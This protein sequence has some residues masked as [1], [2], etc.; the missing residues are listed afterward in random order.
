VFGSFL[1]ARMRVKCSE[2]VQV[3]RVRV[4]EELLIVFNCSGLTFWSAIK[5]HCDQNPRVRNSIYKANAIENFFTATEARFLPNVKAQSRSPDSR[6]QN[7]GETDTP[8]YPTIDDAITLFAFPVIIIALSK[9]ISNLPAW[10]E[11]NGKEKKVTE[12]K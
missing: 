3:G 4:F 8:L 10:H 2:T 5:F 6:L 7:Q 9:V 11:R 12:V 1:T